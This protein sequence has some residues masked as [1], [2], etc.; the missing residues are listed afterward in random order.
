L[1]LAYDNSTAKHRES[2]AIIGAGISGLGAAW[3][4]SE[5]HDVTIYER[6]KQI[7]GHSR[8]K[9]AGPNRDI[10]V[11]TGFMVFN[12]HTYPN[13]INLFSELDV[14]S[15]ETSMSFAVSMDDG[16]FEYA[17]TNLSRVLAILQTPS[18]LNFGP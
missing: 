18:A 10:P 11:D 6:E 2:I 5:H 3:A 13:L 4:L 12:T 8:T 17:L 9:M 1:D 15:V 16:K 14:P 7:G